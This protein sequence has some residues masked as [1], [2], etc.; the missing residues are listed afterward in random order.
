[1]ILKYLPQGDRLLN[2]KLLADVTIVDT[3]ATVDNPPSA[4]KLPTYFEFEYGSADAEVVRVIA[5]SGNI[6]TMERGVN[7]GGVGKAHQQN[8]LY[9][10]KLTNYHWSKVVDAIEQGYLTE[11]T[12]YVFARVTTASFKITASGV[13]RTGM[14]VAGRL[15]RLNGSILVH[16]VSSSYSNP[17]TTVVV[18]ETTVPTPITSIELEIGARADVDLEVEHNT[19]GTHKS[20][21]VTTLGASGAD[22]TAGISALKIVTPKALADAGIVAPPVTLTNTV[23]LTNKR[24]TKRVQSVTSAATVT[25]NS[26]NDDCV[27]ITAQAEA[28]TIANPAGTP[29]NLQTLVIRIL[30]NGTARALTFGDGFFASTDITLP[31]TTVLSKTMYLGFLFNSV[32]GKWDLV[33]KVDNF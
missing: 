29:T 11:D 22:V 7:L 12:S 33:A 10:E 21:L 15:I 24:I 6:I 20:A 8:D 3:T 31:T 23:T 14:Y 25:P 4:S 16:V 17:D 5:V 27:I 32:R 30:D 28:L 1:M 9:K 26:D 18:R 19:N 13:D 2:G